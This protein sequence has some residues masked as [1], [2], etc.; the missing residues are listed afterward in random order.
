MDLIAEAE[1]AEEHAD[2]LRKFKDRV[3]EAARDITAL[4]SELYA[5]SHALRDIERIFHIPEYG[6]NRGRIAEDLQLIRES[7]TYTLD[8]LFRILGRLANGSSYVS[9]S[10]Y[11]M[12]WKDICNYFQKESRLSLRRRLEL[13]RIFLQELVSIVKKSQPQP[14]IMG[15]LRKDLDVL[16]LDQTPD[17]L[18]DQVGGMSLGRS[19][20]TKPRSFERARPPQPPM[21]SRDVPPWAPEPS[22]ASTTTASANDSSASEEFQ[23]WATRAWRDMSA[24]R[25]EDDGSISKCYGEPMPEAKY[26]L[27]EQR[28]DLLFYIVFGSGLK[29]SLYV[30]D[31]ND[32]A[33]ILCRM[34]TSNGGT[35]YYCLPLNTLQIHRRDSTLQLCRPT[36]RRDL[37]LWA[38]LKFTTIERLVIFHCTLVSLR[39]HDAGRPMS[40]QDHVLKHETEFFGG[41]IIDDD[42]CHA[43][44]VFRD[45]QSKAVRLQASVLDGE[46]KNAPVWTAFIH[47]YLGTRGW[48]HRGSARVI[49]LRDLRRHVFSPNYTPQMTDRGEHV[50]RFTTQGDADAFQETIGDFADAYAR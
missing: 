6:R 38:S 2:A 43:L 16:L 8:C 44:R 4:I 30:R 19:V 18:A 35:R 22:E 25:L 9:D 29:V 17:R 24:T 20:P 14:G 47:H 27:E 1:R 10:A 50:L 33:R 13:Y 12:T 7:L 40:N 5:I 21:S 32:R 49:L 45:T 48:L 46:M 15:G 41:R 37:V 3:P 26:R 31:R 23:H 42:Y 34:T 11:A 36:H 28:Y 39:S